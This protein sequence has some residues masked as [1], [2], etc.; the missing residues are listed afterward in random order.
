VCVMGSHR[1]GTV[2]VLASVGTTEKP[3]MVLEIVLQP[4]K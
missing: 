3:P 2:K 4:T 1:A